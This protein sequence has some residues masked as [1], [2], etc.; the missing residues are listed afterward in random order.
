MCVG[1]LVYFKEHLKELLYRDGG[2]KNFYYRGK[3]YSS[4]KA[5]VISIDESCTCMK[6]KYC[7]LGTTLVV[8][9]QNV[10]KADNVAKNPF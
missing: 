5:V 8:D 10:L 9:R 1:E 2:P 7:S 6:V 3:Y 4:C